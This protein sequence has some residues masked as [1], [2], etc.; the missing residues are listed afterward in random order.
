MIDLHNFQETPDLEAV[1]SLVKN[2]TFDHFCE[3]IM[4]V[5]KVKPLF[6]FSRCS[7]AYGWNLKFKKSGKGLCTIY[8][9]E[10]YFTV[11]VVIG[12]KEKLQAEAMLSSCC[13]GLKACYEQCEEGN[14]QRWLMLDVEDEG[15][16]MDDV[17]KL[18]ELRAQKR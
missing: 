15:A 1:S 2:Q 7:F 10:G 17:L 18:I 11:L 9:K 14:G 6:E 16:F 4:T 13:E 8:P 12:Q 5:Y 3:R